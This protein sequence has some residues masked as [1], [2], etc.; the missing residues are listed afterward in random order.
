MIADPGAILLW[1]LEHFTVLLV[2][3]VV[4]MTRAMLQV[5]QTIYGTK[6]DNGLVGAERELRR[7][8]HDQDNRLQVHE[9]RLDEH[10]RRLDDHGSDL[11]DLRRVRP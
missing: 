5:T 9:G 10:D 2:P 7:R 3:L 6:G 4:W 11:R 1:L 8:S